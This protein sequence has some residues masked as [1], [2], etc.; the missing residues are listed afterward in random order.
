[1]ENN[2]RK[3]LS[4]NLRQMDFSIYETVLYLDAYPDDREAMEFYHRLVHQRE[5]LVAEYEQKVGPLTV[6]G[7]LSNTSWNWIKSPWPWEYD[8]N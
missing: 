2:V 7:N 1:M 4:D 3:Q 5:A 6:Y 8:A